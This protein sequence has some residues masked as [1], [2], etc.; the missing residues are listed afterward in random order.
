MEILHKVSD[1]NLIE[2][3]ISEHST[4][5]ASNISEEFKECLN[6][7]NLA[8]SGYA[9]LLKPDEV[10]NHIIIPTKVF[11]SIWHTIAD[12]NVG[13]SFK[14]TLNGELYRP[15]EMNN[16]QE[17]SLDK[18]LEFFKEVGFVV[19][20]D[21]VIGIFDN[22]DILGLADKEK[23]ILSDLTLTLGVNEICNTIIEEYI[24]IK[25]KVSDRTREF[26]TAAISEFIDYMKKTN[27]Y[28]I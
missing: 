1:I 25:Y 24:H 23:I 6:T 5:T 18:A 8:P 4:I 19:P 14:V 11:K 12:D 16:L 28:V 22:K 2:S 13:D 27:A 21:I 7:V 17:A 15:I 20:Y 9:G 3:G 26:Q 10:H